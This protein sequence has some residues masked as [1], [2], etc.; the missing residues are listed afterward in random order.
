[1]PPLTRS[2][3]LLAAL[4]S[5]YGSADW[6]QWQTH[7]WQFYDFIRY[8]TAGTTQLVFFANAFGSTD[9]VSAAQKTY[10]Q[11]NVPKSR[12][13]GQVYFFINQIR[14]DA[15]WLSKG[16]QVSGISSDADVIYTTMTNAMSA[17]AQLLRTGVLRVTLAQ[18]RYYDIEQPFTNTPPGY[19]V[20]IQDFAS[21]Y[22]LGTY[23]QPSI[24]ATTNPSRQNVYSVVPT[25]LVEPEVTVDV[26]IDFPAGTSVALT[27]LVNS[28]DPALE[29]GV[30]FDGYIVRPV[31]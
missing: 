18:K 11:T 10:E 1:M 25:Q 5:K 27:G 13:F 4:Q 3:Q 12:S 30:I 15:R 29:V 19:G 31:Q 26:T 8:P 23:A 17:F 20:Q 6:S 14:C 24:W 21:S 22:I 7:R 16:R 28:V 2:Q 9:P